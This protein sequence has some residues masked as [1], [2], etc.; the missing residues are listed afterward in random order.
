MKKELVLVEG[1][2]GE[3]ETYHVGVGNIWTRDGKLSGKVS[4]WNSKEETTVTCA[5]G[6]VIKI[7][8]LTIQI[9][10]LKEN[11]KD[12]SSITLTW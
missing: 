9:K 6:D 7:G 8:K 11:D 5:K 3:I 12:P 4:V 1:T 2:V 10:S